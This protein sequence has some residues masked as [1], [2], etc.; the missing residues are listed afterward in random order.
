MNEELI[1]KRIKLYRPTC[2]RKTAQ[3]VFNIIDRCKEDFIPWLG[4]DTD[5]SNEDDFSFLN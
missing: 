3:T 5:Y 4:W 1:G 2:N